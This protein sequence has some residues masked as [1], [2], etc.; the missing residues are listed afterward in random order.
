MIEAERSG[1]R[2][3]LLLLAWSLAFG[4]LEGSVVVYLRALFYPEGFRFPLVVLPHR[5][6][7]VEVLREA[8]TIVL[9]LAVSALAY[10]KPLRRFAAFAFCFGVWDLVYYMVLK[11]VL[12]WPPSLLAWDILFLIPVPWIGPMLAPSLVSLALI[13]AAAMVLLGEE[14]EPVRLRTRDW[15]VE[16]AGAVLILISFFWE[17][18]SVLRGGSPQSFPWW[19]FSAGLLLGLVWF[20]RLWGRRG[21]EERNVS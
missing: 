7:A 15:G 16:I 8:A 9:L 14:E 18:P 4:Y 17:L 20:V 10:R 13:V 11:L 19:L 1:T 12:N 6:Y 2:K 3:I 21:P 5:L